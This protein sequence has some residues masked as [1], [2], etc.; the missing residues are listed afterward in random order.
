[1]KVKDCMNHHVCYVK[2]DCNV[3]EA[4]KIMCENHVGC[5]PV[6]DGNNKLVGI[7]TDRDII[8]RCVACDKDA[9]KEPVTNVMTCTVC[10]CM[11]ND[12]VE[13]A[14]KKM[15]ENQIR[16]IPVVENG[17]VVGMLTIGDLAKNENIEKAEL[18]VTIENI[19]CNG[20]QNA[21]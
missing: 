20:S 18:G 1:M 17:K 13:E 12:S 15:E 10:S 11:P 14:E 6:C 8:L 4:S 19:C 16:R 2:N 7:L 9:K 21:E 3:A 5:V